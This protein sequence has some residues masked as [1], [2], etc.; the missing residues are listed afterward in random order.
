M[1]FTSFVLCGV[2]VC[3][4]TRSVV[5]AQEPV[6]CGSKEDKHE[7]IK[8]ER[9]QLVPSPAADRAMIVIVVGG[10]LFKSYQQKLAV[11][12]HWRAV[13]NESQYSFFDVEPGVLRLCWAVRSGT[14]D[15]NFLLLTAQGGETYYIRGTPFKG[16]TELDPA[17]GQTLLRNKTYVTFEVRNED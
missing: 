11:N 15:D 10:S 13:M 7:V 5:A 2:L 12:G 3:L 14:R 4:G 6:S 8:H 17:A 9:D 16:I 1:R